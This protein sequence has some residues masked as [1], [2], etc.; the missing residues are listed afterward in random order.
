MKAIAATRRRF[1]SMLGAAPLAGK[2]VA[3]Q[4]LSGI[5]TAGNMG[6]G[7]FG[8]APNHL[9]QML[10]A[11][12]LYPP[13]NIA[14]SPFDLKQRNSLLKKA[15]KIPALRGEIESLLYEENHAV[16]YLDHDLA[17]KRSFSLAAKVTFQR[18]RN[19]QRQLQ[20]GIVD[21]SPWR[22]AERWGTEVVKKML[23]GMV[24]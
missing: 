5:A 7:G 18:Q 8:P 21:E 15:L 10:G 12:A 11:E 19:V 2:A 14:P 9:S 23:L 17:Q 1:L 16:G 4:A 13:Q 24:S 20:Y 6:D 3:D 22:R